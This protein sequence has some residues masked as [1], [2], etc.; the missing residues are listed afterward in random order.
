MAVLWQSMAGRGCPAGCFVF[1][2]VKYNHRK[3][4]PENVE[5]SNEKSQLF[6]KNNKR[7]GWRKSRIGIL[8]KLYKNAKK[9]T[10][11]EVEKY[12]IKANIVRFMKYIFD[13][14][15]E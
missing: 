5:R 2:T 4:N 6:V 11:R 7:N 8:P 13:K 12:I 10:Q 9:T 1:H 3:K 15:R 14:S